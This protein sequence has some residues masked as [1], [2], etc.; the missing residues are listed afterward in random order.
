MQ[1]WLLLSPPPPTPSQ[2]QRQ[3]PHQAAAAAAAAA[4]ADEQQR[5]LAT[6]AARGHL[7]RTTTPNCETKALFPIKNWSNLQK[8]TD[9]WLFTEKS[10]D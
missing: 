8:V 5:L 1:P 2:Q 6:A 3:Q 7:E 9:F 4:A 10:M